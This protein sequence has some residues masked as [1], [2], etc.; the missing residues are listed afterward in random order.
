MNS[1][2]IFKISAINDI[3]PFTHYLRKDK[4]TI[5]A[6]ACLVPVDDICFIFRFF[7]QREYR[8]QGYG[9]QLLQKL[10]DIA[11]DK[12]IYLQVDADNFNAIKLYEKH[13]FVEVEDQGSVLIYC[14]ESISKPHRRNKHG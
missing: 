14:R 13:G 5:I 6:S 9:S 4:K 3:T 2:T 10:I 7:V 1:T 11:K 12:D 8:Q